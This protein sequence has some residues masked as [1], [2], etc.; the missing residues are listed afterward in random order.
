MAIWDEEIVKLSL[1]LKMNSGNYEWYYHFY[2]SH[3]QT[4]EACKQFK[5]ENEK[6]VYQGYLGWL[7][8]NHLDY[9]GNA[10]I[11]GQPT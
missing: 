2:W 3:G 8:D 5:E 6:N 4:I 1:H 9:I 10:L 7:V 11:E